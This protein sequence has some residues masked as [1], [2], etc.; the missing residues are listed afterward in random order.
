M[1]DFSTFFRELW[2][3]EPFPWQAMLAARV[4]AGRWPQALDLPT[5]SGKTAC[6]E[7]AL[8]A[9]AAQ[10]D[11]PLV[12]RTAPRRIWFVVDR[13]IVVDE[14]FERARKIADRLASATE[15]PLAD[16]AERLRRISGTERPLAIARLRGGVFR[17]DGWARLPSQPAVITSTVDQLGSRLLF[18]GYGRSQLA[19][20]IF[21]GLVANDSLILLDEAHCSVPFLQT[22]RAVET[23]RCDRWSESSLSLPF[24]FVVMSATPPPGLPEEAVFP[25]AARAQALDNPMLKRR[26]EA[27]KVAELVEVKQKRGDLSDDPLVREAVSGA[28]RYV[29]GAKLRVAV[30]VNRVRTA[31]LV[32]DRLRERLGANADVVLLTGRMRPFERD[33]LVERW[34]RFLRA[35]AP[36]DPVNPIV[37]VSTQCL[38]VGA[39][40]SFD[41]LSTEAASLD[42]LRQRFGRL[43]R[44]GDAGGSPA[45]IL[46][47]DRDA[48]PDGEPDPVY[49]RAVTSAWQLL[50]ER[51]EPGDVPTIDFGVEALR[52]RLE[53]VED[54][55]SCLAPSPAAPALLPAH[56]DLLCQTAPVPHPEPDVQ[57]FLHGKDR[58]APEVRVLWRAD[59]DPGEDDRTWLETVALCPPASGEMLA[60]PRTKPFANV[61]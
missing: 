27:K 1:T 48:D 49:G 47:R 34:T 23:Y 37:V 60:A 58:G 36:D 41:A 40:F 56:L 39:D 46:I 14:A 26:L 16:V 6:I 28:E 17:D 25:G 53:D 20:P 21:A 52:A 54:L 24:T 31:E 33:K 61:M 2:S 44:M 12:E 50:S 29:K 7:V 43:D 15:G 32:A 59:L 3:Q 55:S 11:R 22:L 10:A 57:L 38:E 42:A 19:A 5:A 8:W 9:L 45:A 13:R 18:R 30:M 4:A 35:N 51:A